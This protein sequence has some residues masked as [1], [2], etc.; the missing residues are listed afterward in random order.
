MCF[1]CCFSDFF[2]FF[3]FL[4]VADRAFFLDKARFQKAVTLIVPSVD[5]DCLCPAHVRVHCN[6]PLHK[7]GF[8]VEKKMPSCP[9]TPPT[10]TPHT[11][12]PHPTPTPHPHPN[13]TPPPQSVGWTSSRSQ[14]NCRHVFVFLLDLIKLKIFICLFKP[15]AVNIIFGSKSQKTRSFCQCLLWFVFEMWTYVSFKCTCNCSSDSPR[16]S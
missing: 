5:F 12:H 14:H 3:S 7:S 6:I 15:N 9:T 1:C 16:L 4:L 2:F 8:I 10:P 11:P 13:P